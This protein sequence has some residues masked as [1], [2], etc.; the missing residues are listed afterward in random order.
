MRRNARFCSTQPPT[1]D[2]RLQ[3]S[4]NATQYDEC[5]H[6][7]AH[8]QRECVAATPACSCC[9]PRAGLRPSS[10]S[11]AN[12]S[13][14]ATGA[15]NATGAGAAARDCRYSGGN[16]PAG[17]HAWAAGG[18]S[19]SVT[20][21]R[22]CQQ[23]CYRA[24]AGPTPARAAAAFREAGR[25]LCQTRCE[26]AIPALLHTCWVLCVRGTATKAAGMHMSPQRPALPQASSSH[27]P[28][29]FSRPST[30]TSSRHAWTAR[31]LCLG[32]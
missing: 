23:R 11:A 21:G 31:A 13:H 6:W 19:G 5:S 10:A 16:R 12:S 14:A 25:H 30:W 22:V 8:R 9:L 18:A 17:A 15:A 32:Q 29:A 7:T 28:P 2:N 26:K 27:R 1:H 24:P 3:N 4:G 20:G